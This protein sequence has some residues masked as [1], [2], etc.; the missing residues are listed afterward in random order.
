M[1]RFS[2]KVVLGTLALTVLAAAAVLAFDRGYYMT[3]T[4]LSLCM[5]T[6][7]TALVR[8]QWQAVHSVRR[9]IRMMRTS[10]L[11]D[12]VALPKDSMAQDLV[13]E[14][15]NTIADYKKRL[16]NEAVRQH[17][18]ERL[19]DEVDTAVM[20]CR[21]KGEITWQNR[22]AIVLLGSLAR[23]P[24][25]WVSASRP[26]KVRHVRHSTTYEM[27]VS[28]TNFILEE[29]RL[30]IVSLKDIHQVLEE[31]EMEA[32][33]KLVSV[34]TH[35]I[36]NSLSPIIALSEQG[37]SGQNGQP[38]TDALRTALSV[39]HRRSSRLLEFVK[40]YRRLTRLPDPQSEWVEVQEYCDDLSQFFDARL[41]F[42]VQP[43]DLQVYADPGQ[44]MQVLVNL[45]KNAIEAGD[46][47]VI[48]S[49]SRVA[50]GGVEISVRD[51][52]TGILPDVLERI[53]IP[54][55]T[56]KKDGSGIGLSLSKQIVAKHGGTLR[57]W[58][59]EG[60][61]SRFTLWLP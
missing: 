28:A 17:Y 60:Y 1:K 3:V 15:N 22:A 61:G 37:K 12:S 44:L 7:V 32:W 13:E 33:Q 47:T 52:G 46:G 42:D 27:L 19:L 25:E 56:T 23:L 14:L 40:N 30:Y 49:A 45:V 55:F 9:A 20:V 26:I 57:V 18:Y 38:N 50:K 10:G 54:F 8:L 31:K 43:A 5:A 51:R 2:F 24:E 59:K 53:F 35:E 48:L 11:A 39:I 29:Q 21:E 58:S 34:L 4:G 41:Q 6:V 16:Q 36:M